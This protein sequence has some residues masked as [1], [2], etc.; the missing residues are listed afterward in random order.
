[1]TR[2]K[3][4]EFVREREVSNRNMS[5]YC[6]QNAKRIFHLDSQIYRDGALPAK[7]KE[8]LGLVASLVL[9]CEDCINYHLINCYENG[10]S[11]KELA[12]ALTIGLMIGGSITIPHMR[13]AYA[14]WADLKKEYKE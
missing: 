8:L 9:R 13:L 4:E 2:K 7:I 1:M 10:V 5:N 3:I 11:D 6:G 12:E 14:T